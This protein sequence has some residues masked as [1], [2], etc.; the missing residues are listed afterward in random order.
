MFER[1]ARLCSS[2]LQEKVIYTMALRCLKIQIN[3][4]VFLCVSLTKRAS[5]ILQTNLSKYVFHRLINTI[6]DNSH[7]PVDLI[8]KQKNISSISF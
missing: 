6:V 4:T 2:L 7:M 8:L 1:L 5:K 3:C